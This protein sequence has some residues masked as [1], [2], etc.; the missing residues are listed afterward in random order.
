MRYQVIDLTE[1]SPFR[2]SIESAHD[3]MLPM[4]IL[5]IFREIVEIAEELRLINQNMR[6]ILVDLG[7][8][9]CLKISH[10]N[11]L[12]AIHVVRVDTLNPIPIIIFRSV[13]HETCANR[14]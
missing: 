9:L 11:T 5:S 1:G 12:D 7:I 3:H 6:R 8:S 10:R 2:I 13:D 14:L 4:E